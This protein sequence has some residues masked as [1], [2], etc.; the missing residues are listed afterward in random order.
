LTTTN[1][2]SGDLSQ[3]TF[4]AVAKFNST[5]DQNI[6]SNDVSGWGGDIVIG[7]D[8]NGA[9]APNYPLEWGFTLQDNS[10]TRGV[11]TN[12]NTVDTA[13]YHVYAIKLDVDN[14]IMAT[15]VDGSKVEE[16]TGWK[17]AGDV[18][19]QRAWD[20]GRN[21]QNGDRYFNGWLAELCW[22]EDALSDGTVQS[23]SGYLADKYG[24]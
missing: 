9:F 19:T 8:P 16:V 10:S 21:I 24:L 17:I 1:W 12:G 13:G 18:V 14:D 15:Y 4:L 7:I 11:G 22:Y 2:Q 23:V 6:V 20:I 5:A 3:L